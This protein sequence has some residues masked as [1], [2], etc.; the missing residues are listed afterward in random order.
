MAVYSLVCTDEYY[1]AGYRL[2]LGVRVGRRLKLYF[3]YDTVI[4]FFY[5]NTLYKTGRKFSRTTSRHQNAL[6]VR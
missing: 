6:P 5:D 1:K 3:S 4:A 2:A